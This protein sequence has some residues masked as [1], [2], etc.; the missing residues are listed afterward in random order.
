M[1]KS[2]EILPN[3][4]DAP[5]NIPIIEEKPIPPARK[6][7]RRF[8]RE[9]AVSKERP[10]PVLDDELRRDIERIAKQKAKPGDFEETTEF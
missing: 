6:E 4:F 7:F 8:L 2:P 3:S 10:R 9:S 5:E 1:P